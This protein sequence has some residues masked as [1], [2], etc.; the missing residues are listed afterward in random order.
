LR[1]LPFSNCSKGR[2]A[3][4]G[5]AAHAMAP[6]AGLGFLLGIINALHLAGNLALNS[7][8]IPSALKQ[9]SASVAAHSEACLDYTSQ[10]TDLFYVKNPLTTAS[11][12]K[13]I[14]AQLYTLISDSAYKGAEFY[15][16]AMKP[17]DDAAIVFQKYCRG[18]FASEQA[19]GK[20][21]M[22][23]ENRKNQSNSELI[24][25]LITKVGP[26]KC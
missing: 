1:Q 7:D 12:A 2:I 14:Y 25:N 15:N 24:D 21:T 17:R 11:N 19:L 22:S 8:D 3:L 6:T 13:S 4:L 9:Y 18:Y 5:D 16:S 26:G 20:A 10:L 23:S